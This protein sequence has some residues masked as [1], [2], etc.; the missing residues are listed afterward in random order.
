MSLLLNR[1]VEVDAA[2]VQREELIK[3]VEERI[4]WVLARESELKAEEIC[5]EEVER[6]LE[7]SAK[8]L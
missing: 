4:Q 6:E 1:S 5:L 3:E 8:K 7:A 2:C